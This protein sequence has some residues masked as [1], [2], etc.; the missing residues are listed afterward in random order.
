VD[1]RLWGPASLLALGVIVWWLWSSQGVPRTMYDTQAFSDV[2]FD[3][4]GFWRV[5][6]NAGFVCHYPDRVA[7]NCLNVTFS[8]EDATLSTGQE[9]SPY[10]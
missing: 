10:G 7:P 6:R 8:E 4:Y 3:P 1:R 5:H 2:S 9:A